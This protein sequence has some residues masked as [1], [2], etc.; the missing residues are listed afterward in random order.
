LG[1]AFFFVFFFGFG[2]VLTGLGWALAATGAGRFP[3]AGW[4][5]LPGTSSGAGAD[6]G[7]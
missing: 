3:P 2:F 4:L 5:T 1:F 6:S 7:P